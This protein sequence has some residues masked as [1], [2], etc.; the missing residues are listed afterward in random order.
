MNKFLASNRAFL[1]DPDRI[2]EYFRSLASRSRVEGRVVWRELLADFRIWAIAPGVARRESG[3]WIAEVLGGE[4]ESLGSSRFDC[5]AQSFEL[6]VF[7]YLG[8]ELVLIPGGRMRLGSPVEEK[9]RGPWDRSAVEVEVAP[10]LLGR[11][12]MTRSVWAA[13]SGRSAPTENRDEPVVGVNWFEVQATLKNRGLRL[14]QESEWEYAARGGSSGRFC[15]GDEERELDQV[16]WSA[17]SSGGRLRAAGQ[18]QSNAFGLYDMHGLVWEWCDIDG[19]ELMSRSPTARPLR[20][21]AWNSAT[22]DCRSASRRVDGGGR[23]YPI[24]GARVAKSLP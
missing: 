8:Q 11:V 10:F 3:R 24:V 13:L 12:P 23:A 17:R 6:E 4:F 21:G 18:L 1:A 14:P 7:R 15:T 5:A 20:G 2:E 22:R 19:L 16:C 9:G